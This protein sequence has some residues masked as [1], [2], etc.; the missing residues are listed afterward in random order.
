MSTNERD[1][2]DHILELSS[3]L[4]P[5]S[6]RKMFGGYGVFLDG[7]MW[8]LVADSTLYLKVDEESIAD[9]KQC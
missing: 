5:V 7:L 9:F 1:F 8:G 4:G 3:G 2:V 6:A